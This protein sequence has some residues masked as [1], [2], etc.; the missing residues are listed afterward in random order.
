MKNTG[1]T[2]RAWGKSFSPPL[3]GPEKQRVYE[4]RTRLIGESLLFSGTTFPVIILESR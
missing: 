2:E 3:R 4:Q 1:K